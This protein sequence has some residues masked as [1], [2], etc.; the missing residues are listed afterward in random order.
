MVRISLLRR[1]PAVGDG[2]RGAEDWVA[3]G[4][5]KGVTEERLTLKRSV[6]RNVHPA[7]LRGARSACP[8]SGPVEGVWWDA[9]GVCPRSGPGGRGL[10]EPG[11]SPGAARKA[12]MWP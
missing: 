10:G 9:G 7:S 6:G 1:F 5:P 12:N 3:D 8:R 11:G 2:R 4:W